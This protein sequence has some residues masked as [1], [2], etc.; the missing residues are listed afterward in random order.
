MEISR[1]LTETTTATQLAQPQ[2]QLITGE[3]STVHTIVL[4]QTL[5]SGV[6]NQSNKQ[7]I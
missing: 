2:H 7:A 1:Q 3:I 4:I 5:Q 6:T